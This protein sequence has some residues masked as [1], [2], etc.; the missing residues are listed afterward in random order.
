MNYEETLS[1]LKAIQA[2]YSPTPF[3]MDPDTEPRF[4]IN[5]DERII[6]IP[7]EFKFLAVKMDHMSERIYFE[8]PRYFDGEDLATKTCVVQYINANKEEAVEGIASVTDVDYT[9]VSEKIIFRWDVDNNV[10]KYAGDV[11]FSVRFYTISDDNRFT[12]SWNTVP[13]TLPVLDTIDNSGA[14]VTENYPTE[15]ILWQYRMT[16]LDRTISEKIEE[17]TTSIDAD[18]KAAQAARKGAEDAENRVNVI[19]AGNEAYTKQQSHDLFALA[20]RGTDEAAKS[21][22]IYPDKGSNVVVTAHGFTKQEGSGDASPENQRPIVN[23]GVVLQE[24]T[25]TGEETFWGNPTAEYDGGIYIFAQQ[26]FIQDCIASS[27]N[28]A[29]CT[30][31]ENAKEV[32]YAE[33]STTHS[34]KFCLTVGTNQPRFI[35][36]HKLIGTTKNTTRETYLEVFKKFLK[37]R[38]ESGNPVKIYYQK[39]D[40]TGLLYVRIAGIGEDYT[41]ACGKLTAPLCQGDT[42]ITKAK[43][44]CDKVLVL[45]GTQNMYYSEGNS[46][47]TVAV[48]NPKNESYPKSDYIPNISPY[49]NASGLYVLNG[50][51]TVKHPAFTSLQAAKEYLSANPLTVWYRST[52]YTEADDIPVSLET[53]QQWYFELD[54]T[55]NI[56]YASD[57]GTF[58]INGTGTPTAKGG[59]DSGICS[60]AKR[61]Y[62]KDGDGFY[63]NPSSSYLVFGKIYAEGFGSVDAFKAKLVELYAAGT[64]AQFVYPVS[65]PVTYAHD[66]VDFI[67]S[68][69]EEGSWVITGEADGT[70]SAEYNKNITKALE[71]I[72]TRISALELH[73]LG[74]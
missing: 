14:S 22:T 20:L 73:A 43:S 68:P 65:T 27:D 21:I 24:Y 4:V 54:G 71:D 35:V 41:G 11:S 74:G 69:D 59:T 45:D 18:T 47:I 23:S 32:I 10:T 39:A 72:L 52:N 6:E 1:T 42:L 67:A 7:D 63:F 61:V 25:L 38:Y 3:L 8:I 66:P 16:E 26:S 17:A 36:P 12:Y 58:F 51:I 46:Y 5:S 37:R 44:G 55:E 33:N 19:V 13:A 40:S 60:I 53:H 57:V 62:G 50:R 2:S 28:E 9:S 48:D 56:Q 31:F 30:D 49:Q 64:P 34:G 15:L 29:V 70:V